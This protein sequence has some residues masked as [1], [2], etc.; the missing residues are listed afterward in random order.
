MS[1]KDQN[2]GQITI[3]AKNIKGKANGQILE[4]SKKTR[5]TVTG[6]FYQDGKKGGVSHNKKRDRKPP[7]E[8]RVLKVEGPFDEKDKKVDVVEK[9]K[10]YTY[11]VTQ[12]NRET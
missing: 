1:E 7:L 3:I 2:K 9:D 10:W 11:K 8:L 5:N 6:K 4:E 12:F